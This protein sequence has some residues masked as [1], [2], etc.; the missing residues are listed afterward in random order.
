MKV[1]KVWG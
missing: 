1:T